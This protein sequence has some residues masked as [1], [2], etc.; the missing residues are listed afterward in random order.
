MVLGVEVVVEA[1]MV[2]LGCHGYHE[3]LHQFSHLP[4]TAMSSYTALP[5]AVLEKAGKL[6]GEDPKQEQQQFDAC[7]HLVLLAVSFDA[8]D[9]VLRQ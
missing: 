1:L 6:V 7:R 2:V 4:R 5:V 8:D 3:N 9:V